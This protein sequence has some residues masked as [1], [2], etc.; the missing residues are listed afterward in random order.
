MKI[1][2]TAI[3]DELKAFEDRDDAVANSP[4]GDSWIQEYDLIP[5]SKKRPNKKLQTDACNC[6]GLTDMGFIIGMDC[7]K[8]KHL[9]RTAEL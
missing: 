8:H 7:P 2:I 5:S 1:Y 4:Y 3:Y 9:I 6:P